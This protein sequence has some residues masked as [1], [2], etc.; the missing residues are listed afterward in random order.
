MILSDCAFNYALLPWDNVYFH[1]GLENLRS[2]YPADY[3]KNIKI[4]PKRIK[5]FGLAVNMENLDKIRS[6]VGICEGFDLG[7][8]D[9]V[10]LVSFT[11]LFYKISVI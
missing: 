5:F 4:L 2:L 3:F 11:N 1:Y 7:E 9:K 6:P 10:I 8:F